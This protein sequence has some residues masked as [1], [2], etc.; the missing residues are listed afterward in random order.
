MSSI[1]GMIYQLKFLELLLNKNQYEVFNKP[2][3]YCHIYKTSLKPQTTFSRPSKLEGIW[4][5]S[6]VEAMHISICL[7]QE[8]KESRC[9][10][11]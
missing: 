10:N 5:T 1:Q 7:F 4:F 9:K 8:I 3:N 11:Y 6:T 2:L